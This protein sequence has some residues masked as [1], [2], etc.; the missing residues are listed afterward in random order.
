MQVAGVRAAATGAAARVEEVMEVVARAAGAMEV[1][2]RAA[3]V[4]GEARAVAVGVVVVKE[5][6]VRVV[7]ARAAVRAAAARVGVLMEAATAVAEM[8]AVARVE[9]RAAVAR[10]E[11]ARVAGWVV[12]RAAAMAAAMVAGARAEAARALG[13]VG[14]LLGRTHRPRMHGTY[15]HCRCLRSCHCGIGAPHIQDLSNWSR[16]C[17][18]A[19]CTVQPSTHPPDSQSTANT[20]QL[21]AAFDRSRRCRDGTQLL[22][23]LAQSCLA[24]THGKSRCSWLLAAHLQCLV[25]MKCT[26]WSWRHP[27]WD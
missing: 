3:G 17:L 23:P 24:D 4:R 27:L 10:A 12:A 21:Q 22:L 11:V 1:V 15:N 16:W 18:P 5:V 9:A 19:E 25:G 2:V 20:R 6:G 7:A 26:S 14:C 8:V 13:N